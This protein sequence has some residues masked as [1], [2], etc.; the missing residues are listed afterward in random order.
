MPRRQTEQPFQVKL[1]QAQ[2]KAVAE[3]VPALAR[4]LKLNEPGQRSVP[5]T[6]DQLRALK[7]QARG[8][9]RQAGTGKGRVPLRYAFQ[10]CGQALDQHLGAAALPEDGVREWFLAELRAVAGRY[11]WQHV[12][13]DRQSQVERIAYRLWQEEGCPR[14]REDDHWLRA[15]KEFHADKPIRGTVVDGTGAGQAGQLLSPLQAIVH[16][17]TGEVYPTSSLGSLAEN[18]YLVTAGEAGA[19]EAA[20]DAAPGGHS[21][22]FRAAIARAVGL[23]R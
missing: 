20:A 14:G 6:L 7:E 17:K 16:A 1:T 18:G 11:R 9:L 10:A 22:A 2:R 4:R 19:I 21:A 15:E 8:A 12:A 3:V 5:F 13:A 23:E